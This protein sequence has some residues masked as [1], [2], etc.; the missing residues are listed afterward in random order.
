MRKV[1]FFILTVFPTFIIVRLFRLISWYCI[2]MKLVYFGHMRNN[3][4]YGVL[5]LLLQGKVFGK[6]GPDRKSISWL[7]NLTTCLQPPS[8]VYLEPQCTKY[9]LPEWS[10]TWRRRWRSICVEKYFWPF[11]TINIRL[12][13][14]QRKLM[15][16]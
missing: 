8:R 10:R 9:L 3:E 7:K 5:Q 1:T 16:F 4:R 15:Y 11:H 2:L 6:R 14:R 12:N 13:S